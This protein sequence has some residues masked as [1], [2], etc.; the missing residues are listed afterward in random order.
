MRSICQ[1]ADQSTCCAFFVVEGYAIVLGKAVAQFA[2]ATQQSGKGTDTRRVCAGFQ[3]TLFNA[4]TLDDTA[5]VTEEANGCGRVGINRHI[6]DDIAA[7]VI[8]AFETLHAGSQWSEGL[9]CHVD[10]VNLLD[11][12][13]AV[14]S[15]SDI[16]INRLQ[17]VQTFHLERVVF[18]SLT[19]GAYGFR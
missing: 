13:F 5:D 15:Q 16:S 11:I 6:A 17:V 14:A 18:S 19:Q 10:A 3:G 4:Q 1:L 8:V 7:T 12:D 9:A 2:R